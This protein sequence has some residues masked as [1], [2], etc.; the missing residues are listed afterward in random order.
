[1]DLFN[2][3]QNTGTA[4]SLMEDFG[5]YFVIFTAIAII[6]C[7]RMSREIELLKVKLSEAEDEISAFE[8][9]I[10]GWRVHYLEDAG[11]VISGN[12]QSESNLKL[13]KK[14]DEMRAKGKGLKDLENFLTS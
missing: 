2:E 14:I 3:P 1:L 8:D 13:A 10:M 7:F 11:L 9:E 6:V 12:G 5:Y 4:N